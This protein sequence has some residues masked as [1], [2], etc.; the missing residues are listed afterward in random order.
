M[1]TTAGVSMTKAPGLAGM[2]VDSAL[3]QSVWESQVATEKVL[4]SPLLMNLK[5]LGSDVI[6]VDDQK[7]MSLPMNKVVIN[8][9]PENKGARSVTMAFLQSLDDAGVY[10]TTTLIGSEEERRMKSAKAYANDWKHGVPLDTYGINYRELSPYK[11]HAATK[12]D[13]AKWYGENEDYFLHAAIIEGRSPNLA[14]AP[15]SANQPLNPQCYVMG[16]AIS[17][18]PARFSDDD[19]GTDMEDEVGDFLKSNTAA[20]CRSTVPRLLTLMKHAR[21]NRYISPLSLPDGD[22]Y[23]FFMHP[24]EIEYLRDASQTNSFASQ[25]QTAAGLQD[26]KAVV[27]GLRMKIGELYCIEDPRAATYTVAGSNCVF[28][29]SV[30]YVRHGRTDGRATGTTERTH[31]NTNLLLGENA[32]FYMET[33]APHYEKQLDEYKQYENL[34][35]IG[36]CGYCRTDWNADTNNDSTP[37][38]QHEGSMVVFTQRA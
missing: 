14:S 2:D 8:V 4:Y 3:L 21:L 38:V 18:Q 20:N 29:G 35:Y 26:S 30:G 9:T 13:L 32:V 33:E 23:L 19:G 22:G 16:S 17:A 5:S 24:D 15:V 12:R 34:A 7:S 1:A 31:F 28:T 27:P 11:I 36:A 6:A 37:T 10:G 25:W